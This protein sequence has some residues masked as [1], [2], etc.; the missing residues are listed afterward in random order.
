MSEDFK[1]AQ[2]AYYDSSA[3][4]YETGDGVARALNRGFARKGGPGR[5]GPPEPQN[6]N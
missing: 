6:A 3:A 2:L 4:D 5:G 1:R